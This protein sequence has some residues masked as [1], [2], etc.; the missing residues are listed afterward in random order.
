MSGCSGQNAARLAV[1]V[2]DVTSAPKFYAEKKP[3]AAL[4]GKDA[5]RAFALSRRALALTRIVDVVRCS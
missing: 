1:Q 5:S 4:A 3:Y 2:F